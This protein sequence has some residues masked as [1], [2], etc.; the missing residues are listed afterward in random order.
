MEHY[1]SNEVEVARPAQEVYR[2]LDRLDALTPYVAGRVEGWEATED[3]CSFRVQG[4][5]IGLRIAERVPGE[6]IRVA[7]EGAAPV[8][9]GLRVTLSPRG[10]QAC[11]M[12][13]A[14]DVE[15]NMMLRMMVG[16]KLQGAVDR[17][18]QL[19]AQALENAI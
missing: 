17:M 12:Q 10:E 15:L 18:A 8:D 4:F 9:F 13:V 19:A 16:G 1:K 2:R 3:R 6:L 5:P 7:P 11:T 14:L